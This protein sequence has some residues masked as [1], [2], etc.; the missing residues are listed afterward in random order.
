VLVHGNE[1]KQVGMLFN[2]G[3]SGYVTN[4]SVDIAGNYVDK[5][6]SILNR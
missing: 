5:S 2:V 3:A 6:F 4:D 1:K